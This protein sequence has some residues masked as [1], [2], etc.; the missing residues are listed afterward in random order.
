M[1]T[2]DV[3]IYQIRVQG[4][5]DE[6]WSDWLGELTITPQPDGATLLSGSIIDQAALHGIL[7]RLYGLNLTILSVVQVGTDATQ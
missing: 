5:L 1:P 2:N 7:D 6:S 4:Q 3:P